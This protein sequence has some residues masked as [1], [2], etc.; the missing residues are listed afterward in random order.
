MA[1]FGFFQIF[2]LLFLQC[3]LV[4]CICKYLNGFHYNGIDENN[5]VQME[6]W[7][8]FSNKL[9]YEW[10]SFDLKV[11]E[12]PRSLYHGDLKRSPITN[13]LERQYPT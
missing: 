11:F 5:S 8:R 9:A 12:L 6:R 13:K 1:K 4:E 3:D 7:K 10:G 2:D